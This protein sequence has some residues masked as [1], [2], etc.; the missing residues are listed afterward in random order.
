[1]ARTDERGRLQ[2]Y[3]ATGDPR[4]RQE[5]V[6]RFLPLAYSLARRFQGGREPLEDL[7][8]VA[9]LALVK[10]L[11]GFDVGRETAFS[12]YAVPCITGAIKRHFRDCGWAVRVPR[13]LQERALSVQRLETELAANAAESPT[14]A[15]LA[16]A[17]GL[18]AER[19]LEARDAYRALHSNSLDAPHD[20][21]GEEGDASLL[22]TLGETDERFAQALDRSTLDVLLDSLEARD[23]AVVELYYREELTQAQIGRRLGYSQMH[24]SRLLRR[25]I[26]R[27]ELAADC[28][29]G[30]PRAQLGAR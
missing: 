21:Q 17:T 27:L 8:Q 19:V 2:A 12:S 20:G 23:R 5:L 6:E 7:Q 10:A 18:S 9:A 22:D 3:R 1:M 24:V 30:E 14:V 13:D 25:A 15:A 4:L 28:G 16:K 29:D 26:D 11:D